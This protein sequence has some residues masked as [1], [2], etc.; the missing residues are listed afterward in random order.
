[1]P[2]QDLTAGDLQFRHDPFVIV[3]GKGDTM[4]I[5]IR[6]TLAR[7]APGGCGPPLLVTTPGVCNT[8]TSVGAMTA[9]DPVDVSCCV[10]NKC[11]CAGGGSSHG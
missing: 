2:R 5:S 11:A 9:N 8:R 10:D 3:L 1:V 7:W 4:A 6:G